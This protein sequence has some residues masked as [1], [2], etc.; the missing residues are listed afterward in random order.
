LDGGLVGNGARDR[1]DEGGFA[2]ESL[3]PAGARLR[4]VGGWG[5]IGVAVG[6]CSRPDEVVL[7]RHEGVLLTT[8]D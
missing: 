3:E 6:G 1:V 4:R 7:E 5:V 2:P 8:I